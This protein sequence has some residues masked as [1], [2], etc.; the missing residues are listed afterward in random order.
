MI[1]EPQLADSKTS[2]RLLNVW[3]SGSTEAGAEV[4][5]KRI[6]EFHV[7]SCP[8]VQNLKRIAQRFQPEVILLAVEK[9]NIGERRAL[10]SLMRMAEDRKTPVLQMNLDDFFKSL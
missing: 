9:P 6:D 2:L 3:S 1:A 5:M 8:L 4:S 10:N 7:L